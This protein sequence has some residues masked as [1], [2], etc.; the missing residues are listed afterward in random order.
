MSSMK[1]K[2]FMNNNYEIELPQGRNAQF[3]VSA[4]A[5]I[6]HD[7]SILLIKDGRS[8]Q[9]F[10]FPGGGIELG[11]SPQEA[12]LREIK[13]ETGYQINEEMRV[14]FVSNENYYHAQ[15][16]EYY[17]GISL[18]FI[19]SLKS[20]I[21]GEQELDS[22]DEIE[23]VVWVKKNELEESMIADFHKEAFREYMKNNI[24]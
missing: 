16:D 20:T 17:C 24:R 18:F 6:E 15:R 23:E 11:Q 7:D 3:R 1:F 9:G 12:L 2:D 4:T 22:E 19:C 13:E 10:E 8:N 14:V 21:Q 5:I